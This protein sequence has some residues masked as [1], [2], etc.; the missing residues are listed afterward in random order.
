MFARAA[1]AMSASSYLVIE[2]TIDLR[3]EILARTRMAVKRTGLTLSC[4]VPKMEAR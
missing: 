2:T 4:S 1:I 3:V